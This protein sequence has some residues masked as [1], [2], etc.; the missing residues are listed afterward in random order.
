MLGNLSGEAL[1]ISGPLSWVVPSPRQ[2]IPPSSSGHW[3]TRTSKVEKVWLPVVS[4]VFSSSIYG[5]PAHSTA[6]S[7]FS[8]SIRNVS[9]RGLNHLTPLGGSAHSKPT[10]CFHTWISGNGPVQWPTKISWKSPMCL[11]WIQ[12]SMARPCSLHVARQ[13]VSVFFWHNYF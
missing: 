13:D 4:Y 5:K 7:M 9:W 10:M 6:S 3:M 8:V 2:T 12:P 11:K 1:E